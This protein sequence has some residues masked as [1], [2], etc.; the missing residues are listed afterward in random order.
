MSKLRNKLKEHISYEEGKAIR[1]QFHEFAKVNYFP[2]Y[3]VYYMKFMNSNECT[4]RINGAQCVNNIYY[5]TLFTVVSQHV[6]GDC[7]EECLDTAIKIWLTN[8]QP[9]D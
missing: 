8:G 3:M 9:N 2:K 1:E 5:F 4:F 7:I 6:Q